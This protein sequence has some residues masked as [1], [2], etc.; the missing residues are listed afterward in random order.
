MVPETSPRQTPRDSSWTGAGQYD[1]HYFETGLG[2][3]YNRG[4]PHWQRFFDRVADFIVSEF[5]P[6]TV[7]DA[8][9]AIG[10]LVEALRERGV[11]ARGFDV[12]D[13]AIS[14]VP[15]ELKPFCFVGSVTDELDT[16]YDL[17]T[18]IEVL[19]HVPADAAERAIDNFTQHTDRILFSSSPDD[20]LEPTHVN[21]Q[22]PDAWVRAFAERGFFPRV[23]AA[24]I[25]LSPQAIVFERRDP[26][27]LDEIGDYEGVRYKLALDMQNARGAEAARTAELDEERSRLRE[28]EAAQRKAEAEAEVAAETIRSLE[29]SVAAAEARAS[30]HAASR[31]REVEALL[32]RLHEIEL[33]TTWRLTAPLRSFLTRHPRLARTARR[34][35]KTTYWAVTLQ[36]PRR[37]RQRQDLQAAAGPL[38]AGEDTSYDRW[39]E[40]YDTVSEGDFE[41]MRRLIAGLEYAPLISVVLPVHETPEHLLRAA[42]DSVVAQAYENWE[43][44]VADD[45]STAPHVTRTLDEYAARDTRIKRVRLSEGGGT[46]VASNAA[47]ELATGDF[48]ALLDHDDELRP[49]ALLMVAWALNRDPDTVFLYSDEDKLDERGRR[50]DPY[51]KPDWN[52]ALVLAQNY[53]CHLSAFR[54]DRALEVGG[55]RPE[56]DGSQ[57]WDLILRLTHG[58]DPARIVH[59]PHILYHWRAIATS[60]ARAGAA[61]PHTVAAGTRAV[62]DHL[63]AAGVD[64]D[65]SVVGNAF[66]RV[67][68]TLPDPAP[69]VEVII[70]T[71][72]SHEHVESCLRG[73]LDLTSYPNVHVTLVVNEGATKTPAKATLMEKIAEDRRVDVLTYPDRPF[74]YS[75]TNNMAI[76]KTAAEIICLLNDD[77]L[78]IN[79][80]WLDGMV[81]HV[82]QEGVGAVGALLYYPNDTVQHGGVILGGGGVADHFHRNLPRGEPGY[83]ARAWLDQ[84]LSCVTAGCMVLRREAFTDAGGF[85]ETLAI[86]FNDVDFCIRLRQQGWRIVWTAA[87]EL[88][89]QES[90]SLGRHDSPERAD[91]FEREARA[92]LDRWGKTLVSD[93]H[94]NP[95]LSLN[96]LN[97]LAFPPRQPYPWRLT[98][99][100]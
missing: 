20:L 32:T 5:A 52:P 65:V 45:A 64:A 9:C 47:L 42:F 84:D 6:E 28:I 50:Y 57:D 92:L 71:A 59:I 43:L 75:W 63:K 36:L 88:Y 27:L 11:E 66:Q 35:L 81:G 30:H 83:F 25:V 2:T 34:G 85:D 100:E 79:R 48:V 94:Y 24:A 86:A 13:Y 29:N 89:H 12:S 53:P 69:P 33:S 40:L 23:T 18:C 4:N 56:F 38:F 77:V 51:F 16:A 68:Y 39:V 61:K 44:C 67:R 98:D 10:L 19:E 76:G 31:A 70:P 62:T 46:S 37:L 78:V 97:K 91:E 26:S 82:L 74:N 99:D 72:F 90:I 41:A 87:A 80:D 15:V 7:L 96:H 55:F 54:R 21:V 93:P 58:I 8:G 3:P 95:N 73:L 14:Q 1:S 49:N 22:Q 17:I 60:T